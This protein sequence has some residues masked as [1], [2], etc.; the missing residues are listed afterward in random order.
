[1]IGKRMPE[2]S[3]FKLF[4]LKE[5]ANPS[6]V[7]SSGLFIL[8]WAVLER[9]GFPRGRLIEISGPVSGGKSYVCLKTTAETQKRGLKTVWIDAEHTFDQVGMMWAEVQGVDSS[10]LLVPGLETE[11]DPGRKVSLSYAQDALRCVHDLAEGGEFA[12]IVTDS[13]AALIPK[14]WDEG[15]KEYGEKGKIMDLAAIA[16]QAMRDISVAAMKGNCCVIFVN[17]L[18]DKPG[19]LWGSPTTTPGGHALKFHASLR[20]HVARGNDI[21]EDGKMVGNFA[22]ILVE[23]SRVSTPWIRTGEK[24]GIPP[25]RVY[26]DGRDPNCLEDIIDYGV[27]KGVIHQN[28]P[29]FSFEDV[30]IRGK[31]TFAQALSEE[32]WKSVK[33]QLMVSK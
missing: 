14:G 20:L 26:Y 31:L 19:S 30:K 29:M 22:H 17:Q 4:S 1:V 16:S 11:G 10:Q 2:K 23:K 25:I 6:E 18:R 15:S 32:K 24:S 28:G 5:Y 12:L 33:E 27:I 21:I 9:G 7:L 8:D 13:L 3:P